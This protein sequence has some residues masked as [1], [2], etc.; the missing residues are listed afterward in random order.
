MIIIVMKFVWNSFSSVFT[1][2]LKLEFCT[3]NLILL[4]SVYSP[5]NVFEINNL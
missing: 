5:V 2:N 3:D 4:N 1:T